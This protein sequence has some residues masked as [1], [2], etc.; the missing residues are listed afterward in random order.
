MI[1]SDYVAYFLRGGSRLGVVFRGRRR[2]LEVLVMLPVLVTLPVAAS[3]GHL[4]M[5]SAEV[6]L[7]TPFGMEGAL[8]N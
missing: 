1:H 3:G 4:P 7:S 8:R 2:V 6:V 5:L